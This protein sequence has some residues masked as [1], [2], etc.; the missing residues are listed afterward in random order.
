MDISKLKNLGW[1]PKQTVEDNVK[2]YISWV[3]QYP[4]A[5]KY[6]EQTDRAMKK[7]KLLF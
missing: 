1:K 3:S 4:E 6:L 2:E 5:K 7:G